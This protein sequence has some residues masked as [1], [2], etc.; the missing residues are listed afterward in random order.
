MDS[1]KELKQWLINEINN[2]ICENY[3]NESTYAWNKGFKKACF[4]TLDVIK[5][6]ENKNNDVKE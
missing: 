2:S 4:K 1:L 5:L 3:H 6:I